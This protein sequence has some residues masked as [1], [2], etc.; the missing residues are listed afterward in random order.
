MA[1]TS[2]KVKVAYVTDK[3]FLRPTLLSVWS[4]LQHLDSPAELHMWGNG[5]EPADW[6]DVRN[7]VSENPLIKL[8]CKD[9]SNGY[10]DGAHGPQSYI[11]AATMGRLFIPRMIDDYVLYIDGDTLVTGD[12]ARAFEID[13][14]DAYAGVVRDYTI[15][16]WLANPDENSL[17]RKARLAEIQQFMKPAS[18][19]DYFN[20]GVLLLNCDK[21]CAE[22]KLLAR[23]E[24][25]VAASA[26]SHGDQDHLNAL[27]N[28]NVVQLDLG[29]NAS[30]GRVRKHRKFLARSG[31]PTEGAMRGAPFILHYHG[32]EK[33]WRRVQWDIWSS[34]GRATLIYQRTLR[35]FLQKHPHL[36]PV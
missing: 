26:C 19:Q 24:D 15:A 23:I 29:W 11:S 3:G 20:A 17:E 31:T 7:V 8:V 35:R 12:V 22:P 4:L 30:W 27:F 28:G 14:G 36:K 5:L 21:L 16:H 34:R 9:I 32:P 18:S 10:L 13:L 33:P 25:V 2:R 6:A 1:G